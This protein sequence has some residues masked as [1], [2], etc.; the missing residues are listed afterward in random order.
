MLILIALAIILLLSIVPFIIRDTRKTALINSA[1]YLIVFI[2]SLLQS[3]A[4]SNGSITLFNFFYMDGLSGFF[5]LLIALISFA[6]SVYSIG[7]IAESGLYYSLFNLFTFTMFFS[8]IVNNLGVVWVS[9]ELTTL[10]SA[11]LVG[12]Y[13]KEE[14]VEAAWK[15]IIICSVGISLALLGIILFYHTTSVDG[16]I[17]SLN[18]T[19]MFAA[20][21]KLNPNILKIGFLFVLVGFGTKAGIAPMH[22]WLPDA[23]SQALT[24]ISALLSGVLLK[25]S[26]YVIIRFLIIVNKGLGPQFSGHLLVFFGILSIAVAAIFI[27]VQK[28]IKRLLAYSSIEHIGIIIF[29]L[30]IGGPLGLFGAVFHM[31]NHAATK[32]LMFFGAGNIVKKY[33]TNDMRVIRGVVKAMPFTGIV[34]ILGAFALSGMPPFSIFFSELMILIAG[35]NSG[36]YLSSFT[37]LFIVALA[38]GAMIYHFARSSFGEK[39]GVLPEAGE[40]LSSKIALIVLLVIIT[41]AGMAMP[42]FFNKIIISSTNVIMRGS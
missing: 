7:Y 16:G 24:P 27:L 40:N 20:A 12:F 6:S 42:G 4:L 41:S 10:V 21:G 29:A 32:S 36:A 25:T 14:S 15:Y 33:S 30:G 23:H 35:F 8:T 28:D 22:T 37:V 1:G 5:I 34:V 19:D 18:W 2:L 31:F 17:R 39:P 13:N 9:I 11:F 26:L 3:L 38:F